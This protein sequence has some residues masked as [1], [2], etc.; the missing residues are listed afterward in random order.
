MTCDMFDMWWIISTKC[1]AS[2]CLDNLETWFASLSTTAYILRS[3]LNKQTSQCGISYFYHIS[4]LLKK[5]TKIVSS[6]FRLLQLPLRCEL[7][8]LFCCQYD[9]LMW[10]AYMTWHSSY[11]KVSFSL[12]SFSRRDYNNFSYGLHSPLKL[13]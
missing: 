6:I 4:V 7:L 1:V 8:K 12:S 5:G 9:T 13:D 3:A 10:Q 11:L 2:C